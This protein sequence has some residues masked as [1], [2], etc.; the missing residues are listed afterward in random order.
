VRTQK[1]KS[2]AYNTPIER[3]GEQRNVTETQDD[4]MKGRRTTTDGRAGT[5]DDR[6]D[7]V[8]VDHPKDVMY[9]MEIR[10][11]SRPQYDRT[12]VNG[13]LPESDDVNKGRENRRGDDQC[14]S[15]S[16]IASH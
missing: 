6:K 16:L 10:K 2:E 11:N 4:Q 1:R 9:G 3:E 12:I 13:S 7:V 14:K 15:M 5:A 8:Y